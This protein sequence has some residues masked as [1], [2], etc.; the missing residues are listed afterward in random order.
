MAAAKPAHADPN[1]PLITL[2]AGTN[3]ALLPK[4]RTTFVVRIPINVAEGK[5]IDVRKLDVVFKEGARSDEL[6]KIFTIDPK[7]ATS[8]EGAA[9]LVTAKANLQPG[10]YVISLAIAPTGKPKEEQPVTLSLIVPTPTVSA[11]TKIVVS[12][13][14]Y[15]WGNEPYAST[16]EIS[17]TSGKI[18]AYELALSEQH[19][20]PAQ[21]DAAS[22]ALR[23]DA[24]GSGGAAATQAAPAKFKVAPVAEFPLGTTNGRITITSPWLAAPLTVPFEVRAHRSPFLILILAALGT[25]VG[26]FVRTH[27]TQRQTLLDAKGAIAVASRTVLRAKQA[28]EDQPFRNAMTDLLQQLADVQETDDPKKL[29]DAAK[30]VEDEVKKLRD[31]L[32]GRVL[33]IASKIQNVHKMVDLSWTLPP[34]LTEGIAA[35]KAKV[36]E[37]TELLNRRNLTEA[38]RCIDNV[39]NQWVPELARSIDRFTSDLAKYLKATPDPLPMNET[40]KSAFT[41]L[42]T[43][44]Q[45]TAAEIASTAPAE[46]TEATVVCLHKL[47]RLYQQVQRLAGAAQIL[48]NNVCNTAEDALQEAFGDIKDR[49]SKIRDVSAAAAKRFAEGIEDPG[50]PAHELD[51][52]Q[53]RRAWRETLESFEPDTPA[54]ELSAAIESGNW[55][56]AVGLAIATRAGKPGTD[57]EHTE[58]LRLM[59]ANID[60]QPE[61]LSGAGVGSVTGSSKDPKTLGSSLPID[62]AK[63]IAQRSNDRRQFIA[64]SRATAALQSACFGALFVVGAYTAFGDAWVGSGKDMLWI[65]VLAFGVDLSSDSVLAALKKT[66]GS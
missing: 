42:T 60:I 1:P 2:I 35:I 26:W 54:P 36:N 24:E 37:A 15:P 31:A 23:F 22:G 10:T 46:S 32:E 65:F 43:F 66:P 62:P 64:Q 28:C 7:P 12:Q 29:N 56:K 17:E 57:P 50:N 39:S 49:F 9:L 33:G 59:A 16:L 13:L 52:I 30:A 63:E 58:H 21:G 27:L 51:V 3:Q 11:N 55:L 18:G 20:P 25:L 40:A 61:E 19:D 4:D 48:S 5:A 8:T 44:A 6:F 45:T 34:F 38:E 41:E 53:L 47:D 14:I